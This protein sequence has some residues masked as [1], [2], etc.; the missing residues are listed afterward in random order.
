MSAA[1]RSAEVICIDDRPSR[2]LPPDGV[3][4]GEAQ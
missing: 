1:I 4:G 3:P 2:E